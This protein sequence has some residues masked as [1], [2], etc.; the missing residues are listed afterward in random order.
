MDRERNITTLSCGLK[1]AALTLFKLYVPQDHALVK[2]GPTFMDLTTSGKN[3]SSFK[4]N[5]VPER[6]SEVTYP[7]FRGEESHQSPLVR[8]FFFLVERFGQRVG[9]RVVRGG[10]VPR[11]GGSLIFPNVPQS[12]LGILRVPQLPPP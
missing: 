7:F 3:P 8:T 9:Y 4:Q 6:P 5:F 10:G 12:S 1:N 2:K 11:G